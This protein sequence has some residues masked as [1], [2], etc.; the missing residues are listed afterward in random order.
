MSLADTTPPAGP[1]RKVP[2]GPRAEAWL[3]TRYDEA[4]RALLDPTI[5][6]E[7]LHRMRMGGDIFPEELR[8]AMN[9]HM[10]TADPPEH[11]RLRKL[12]STAFTARR[13]EAMRSR[14]TDI[15]DALLDAL[16]GKEEAD[17]IDD[18]AFPL[19]FQVI[20]ELIGV[21]DVDRDR[22]RA[23]SNTLVAGFGQP[24]DA[25]FAAAAAMAAYCQEL[26]SRKRSQPD[27]ALLSGL[28]QASDAGDRLDEDE[29]TSL[30]FLMLVAGHETTVNLIGNAMYVL[31][32]KPLWAD[33][34]RDDPS[35]VPHAIEV[36]LGLESPV[37]TATFRMTT[38]PVELGD[39]TIPAGELVLISLL[40]A[41]H[42]AGGAPHIAFGHG[43]HFCLGA[44]LAR[45]EG[46]VAVGSLLRR[47]PA[48][49]PAVPLEELQWRPGILVR[50]LSHLPVRLRDN[51]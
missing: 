17:L 13:M 9:K 10:L 15:S 22:F 30:I 26:V 12:V 45:V 18:Y 24:S 29:L 51:C 4:K 34:L 50:G 37:K 16:E 42:D 27:D 46:Q 35:L 11:T 43:I 8:R 36:V 20:C 14:V 49:R 31:F 3:I 23:W 33:A 1:A 32:Q 19:P 40:A 39:V 6:K 41:N 25:S 7:P 38:A 5:A 21:P 2:L 28:I 44:P 47:F 48:M